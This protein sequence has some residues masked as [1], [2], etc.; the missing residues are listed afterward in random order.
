M[1]SRVPLSVQDILSIYMSLFRDL[2][3]EAL[4]GLYLHGSIALN[5]YIKALAILIL[6]QF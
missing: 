1:D 3:P 4:E 6:L 2:I 5:A